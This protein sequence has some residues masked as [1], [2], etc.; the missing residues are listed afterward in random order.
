MNF[1]LRGP[2]GRPGR[3]TSSPTVLNSFAVNPSLSFCRPLCTFICHRGPQALMTRTPDVGHTSG[4]GNLSHDTRC[5]PPSKTRLRAWR[6]PARQC[7][8]SH[9][10]CQPSFFLAMSR[11][12]SVLA[13]RISDGL[14]EMRDRMAGCPCSGG[15]QGETTTTALPGWLY[16]AARYQKLRNADHRAFVIFLPFESAWWR[17]RDLPGGASLLCS[18]GARKSRRLPTCSRGQTHPLSLS[19]GGGVCPVP[20]H[21]QYQP[22]P[23]V[24]R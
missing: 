21:I 13:D 16:L 15:L 11:P 5:I 3:P 2:G 8:A 10:H 19:R 4:K 1:A 9:P 14:A 7:T 20:E 17:A 18:R 22:K 12:F 6:P 24:K 23:P